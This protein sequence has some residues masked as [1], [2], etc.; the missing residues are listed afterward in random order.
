MITFTPLNKTLARRW[1]KLNIGKVRI[2]RTSKCYWITGWQFEPDL[3]GLY[4]LAGTDGL[5]GVY[6]NLNR[7]RKGRRNE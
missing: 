4:L 6:I 1:L 2:P 3:P 5:E 7:Q